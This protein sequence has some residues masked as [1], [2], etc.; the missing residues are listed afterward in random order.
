M[1]RVWEECD[2]SPT[3]TLLLESCTEPAEGKVYTMFHGTWRKN[4]KGILAGGFRPS[5]D[6]MLGQGVYLSRDPRKACRYPLSAPENMK[7]LLRVSVNVGRVKK[8]NYRGH[9]LQ[10]TWHDQGYDTAWCPP[11]CGM[12]CSGLEEDCVWDPKRINI[13]GITFFR[14]LES[15]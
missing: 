7:V 10:K 11:N 2:F 5:S 14:E 4:L 8:I 13:T 1:E 15:Q 12:V 9:P 6:G 3:D